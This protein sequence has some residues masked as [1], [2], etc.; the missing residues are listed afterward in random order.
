M[1]EIKIHY[2]R[3]INKIRRKITST[4]SKINNNKEIGLDMYRNYTHKFQQ[5]DNT[6]LLLEDEISDLNDIYN[7]TKIRL[8]Q[9]KNPITDNNTFDVSYNNGNDDRNDDRND[10]INKLTHDNNLMTKK[11]LDIL[12]PLFYYYYNME[13]ANTTITTNNNNNN[14]NNETSS[15]FDLHNNE[16]INLDDID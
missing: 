15:S 14:N 4:I 8:H 6:L 10:D 11:E 7:N 9:E 16:T 12:I 1:D 13:N 5:L 3:S 2:I